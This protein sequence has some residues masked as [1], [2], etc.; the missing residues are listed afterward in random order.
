M[1][2]SIFTRMHI[3]FPLVETIALGLNSSA[4]DSDSYVS[5]SLRVDMN[6]EKN[7]SNAVL[8]A[9]ARYSN[10]QLVEGSSVCLTH[11][12]NTTQLMIHVRTARPSMASPCDSRSFRYLRRRAIQ[13]IP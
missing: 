6:P 10:S 7:V 4:H 13:L 8:I 11:F 3:A 2:L 5:G 1:H 9:N 12:G